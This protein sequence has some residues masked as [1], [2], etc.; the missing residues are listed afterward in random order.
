[1]CLARVSTLKIA[2]ILGEGTLLRYR[3][4]IMDKLE[5][6]NPDNP[7]VVQ[8]ILKVDGKKPAKTKI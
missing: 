8:D 6:K 2:P 4:K 1:M 3:R 5:F 7:L